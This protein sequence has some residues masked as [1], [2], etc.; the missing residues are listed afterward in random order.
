MPELLE[1]NKIPVSPAILTE[2][3][4]GVS[5][6]VCMDMPELIFQQVLI[7]L[8]I[9]PSA[10]TLIFVLPLAVTPI[11]ILRISSA[12]RSLPL[13]LRP[14]CLLHMLCCPGLLPLTLNCR[15][16]LLWRRVYRG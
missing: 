6:N 8:I 4:P 1:R 15:A 10:S 3:F 13:V 9:T 5:I 16:S 7:G 2:G 14:W 11:G 12:L